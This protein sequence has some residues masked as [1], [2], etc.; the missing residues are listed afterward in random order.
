MCPAGLQSAVRSHQVHQL[1]PGTDVGL[2]FAE[3]YSMS[4]ISPTPKRNHILKPLDEF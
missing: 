2:W 4:Q 3:H 1:M